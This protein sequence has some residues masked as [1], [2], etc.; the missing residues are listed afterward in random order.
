MHV[1]L[2]KGVFLLSL[3]TELAWGFVHLPESQHP[4]HQF[5]K[6]RHIVD[7]LLRLMERYEI[8]A[9]WAVVGHLFL[10]RCRPVNGQKHP[11]IVRP[12]CDWLPRDWLGPDPCGDAE[13]HPFW[14]APDIVDSILGCRTPQEIGCHTF[15]HVF[16]DDPGCT[17]ESFDSELRACKSLAEQRGIKLRSFVFPKNRVGHTDL[18]ARHGFTSYRGAQSFWYAGLRRPM[19]SIAYRIDSLSP[20]APEVSQPVQTNGV[21]NFPASLYYS[22]RDGWGRWVPVSLRVLKAKRGLRN[23]V[24]HRGIFHLWFHPYN[25]ATDMEGLLTG[26]ERIFT[27][28]SQL[29]DEGLIENPTMGDLAE[30]LSNSAKRPAAAGYSRKP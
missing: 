29:R 19:W 25:I 10:E 23:A 24:K 4:V 5:S 3:D 14:Y 1:N 16:A 7:R 26:L 9:T 15:S 17:E 30:Q 11:E 12:Q 20:L 2:D 6:V 13:Q 28:V 22:H 18:L 27:V 21:W 8:R